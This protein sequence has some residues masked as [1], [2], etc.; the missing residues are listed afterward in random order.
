MYTNIKVN[1]GDWVTYHGTKRDQLKGQAYQVTQVS[2]NGESIGFDAGIFGMQWC[3]K[4]KL[5][6]TSA[7]KSATPVAVSRYGVST[8]ELDS[9]IDKLFMDA[10][11]GVRNV[12]TAEIDR[13]TKRLDDLRKALEV[14]DSL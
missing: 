8:D 13:L 9:D 14:I 2:E 5:E 4:S 1:V 3:H 12:L 11:G 10:N 7:P 6:L